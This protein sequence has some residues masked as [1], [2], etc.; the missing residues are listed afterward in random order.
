MTPREN[1]SH[2]HAIGEDN[3]MMSYNNPSSEAVEQQN[4]AFVSTWM[5]APPTPQR[6]PSVTTLSYTTW[7][8][9]QEVVPQQASSRVS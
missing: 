1:R 6:W 2:Y 7:P 3:S 9:S 5:T 8:C 4:P